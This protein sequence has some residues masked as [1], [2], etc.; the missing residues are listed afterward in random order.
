[1]HAAHSSLRSIMHDDNRMS[2]DKTISFDPAKSVL[3][4]RIGEEIKLNDT[5]FKHLSSVLDWDIERRYL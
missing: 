3:N 1:M 2:P 4:C 5:A